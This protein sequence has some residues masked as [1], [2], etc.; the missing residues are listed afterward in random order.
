M[1]YYS[2][3]L[4]KSIGKTSKAVT[5]Y[6]LFSLN[7]TIRSKIISLGIRKQSKNES[8]RRSRGGG[9]SFLHKIKTIVDQHLTICS[10][11]TQRSIDYRN[12]VT[13]QLNDIKSK[14]YMWISSKLCPNKLQISC[15]QVHRS[16][17]LS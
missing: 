8:Y 16:F 12:I 11:K 1:A 15:E 9:G 4:L 2:S 6:H 5:N 14:S 10:S 7:N 17:R 3:T 13:V